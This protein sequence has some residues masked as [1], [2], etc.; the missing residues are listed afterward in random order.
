[1]CGME[2]RD[3]SNGLIGRKGTGTAVVVKGRIVFR[4]GID[5][6]KYSEQRYRVVAG[7]ALGRLITANEE[8]HHNDGDCVNDLPSN[9]VVCET[10]EVHLLLEAYTRVR[11]AGLHTLPEMPEVNGATWVGKYLKDEEDTYDKARM[12]RITLMSKQGL[13][14]V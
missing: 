13:L 14:A 9:L 3:R 11:Q 12:W 1:M 7:F 10:H 6:V 4:V 2:A 5:Q 8:V